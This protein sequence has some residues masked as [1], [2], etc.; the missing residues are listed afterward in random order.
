LGE[1]EGEVDVPAQEMPGLLRV[2][3]TGEIVWDVTDADSAIYT[4]N[5]PAVRVAV[6]FLGGKTIALGDV[7]ISVIKAESD[8]ASIAVAALDGKPIADSAKVLV[9]AVGRVE[10]QNMGWNEERTSVSRKWGDGP[11]VAE[12]IGARITLP[13]N[14]RMSALSG[15]GAPQT[16]VTTAT[17]ENGSTT[18]EIGANYRTLW[19]GVMP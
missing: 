13:G 9:V 11:T 10:N 7:S 6:G 12:G 3:S 4:V 17:A 8:W 14:R 16:T 19:Y 15:T 2:S 5:A 1:G 18:Y